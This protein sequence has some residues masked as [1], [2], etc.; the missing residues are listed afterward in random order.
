MERAL[1]TGV[2]QVE[3]LVGRKL[4]LI[5]KHAG[6]YTA[7]IILNT[8]ERFSGSAERVEKQ[9]HGELS[10]AFAQPTCLPSKRTAYPFHMGQGF[11]TAAELAVRINCS[12]SADP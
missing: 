3:E 5:S 2:P 7:R 6:G 1:I 8:A 9:G 11:R 4:L 10:T 12:R